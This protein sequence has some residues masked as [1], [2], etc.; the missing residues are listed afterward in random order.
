MP[1]TT[2]NT[3]CNLIWMIFLVIQDIRLITYCILGPYFYDVE[4]TTFYSIHTNVCF[5]LA[6]VIFSDLLHQN[7]EFVLIL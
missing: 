7:K 2:S 1:S 4:I 5:V 6:P 3:L